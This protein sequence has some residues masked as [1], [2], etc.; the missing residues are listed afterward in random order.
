[1]KIIRG[2][3]KNVS[4]GNFQM[5][6]HFATYED[7]ITEQRENHDFEKIR[8]QLSDQLYRWS[9]EDVFKSIRERRE[10]ISAEQRKMVQAK[11]TEQFKKTEND[12]GKKR[13]R[14]LSISE[15]NKTKS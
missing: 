11:M 15:Q 9:K 4:L 13:G 3:E 1:M 10:E 12:A 14:I 8:K 7:E 2:Y 5:E 6:K